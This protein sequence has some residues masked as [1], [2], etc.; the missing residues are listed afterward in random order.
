MPWIRVDDSLAATSGQ[1]LEPE[2]YVEPHKCAQPGSAENFS[3]GTRWQCE[4]NAIW[5]VEPMKVPGGPRRRWKLRPGT[6]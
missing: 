5:R 3:I 1:F 4:C 6:K 2:P